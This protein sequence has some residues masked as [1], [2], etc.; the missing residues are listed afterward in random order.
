MAVVIKHPK[1][2]VDIEPEFSLDIEIT[3][4]VFSE[5]G[6]MTYPATLPS[7]AHNRMILNNAQ[8]IDA[9]NAP[10]HDVRVVVSDGVYRRTGKLNVLSAGLKSG[11]SINIGFDEGEMYSLFEDTALSKLNWPV[12]NYGDAYTAGDHLG[13]VMREEIEA[14][15]HVFP[16]QTGGE[17]VNNV[18]YPEYLNR[19]AFS[20]E[21]GRWELISEARYENCVTNGAVVKTMVPEGYGCTPFLKVHYI[22]KHIFEHFGYSL[23]ENPFASHIQLKRMVVLNNIADAIV[24]GTIDY[25]EFLPDCSINEFFNSLYVRTGMIYF[26]DGAKKTV[27]IKF[28]KDMVAARGTVDWKNYMAS[29]PTISFATPKRVVLSANTG[30]DGAEPQKETL[31]QFLAQYNNKVVEDKSILFADGGVC[32]EEVL[33]GEAPLFYERSTGR[34]YEFDFFDK[35]IKFKSTELFPWDTEDDKIEKEELTG[36][37]EC[38]AMKKVNWGMFAGLVPQYLAGY[39]H[40]HT[41]ISKGGSENEKE[42]ETPLAFCFKLPDLNV[43]TGNIYPYDAGGNKITGFDYALTFTGENGAFNRFFKD[44]DAI[45]RH[46]NSTVECEINLPR[47]TLFSVDLT[48]PVVID[49]QRFLIE[50]IKHPLPLLPDSPPK[51]KL[52]TLKL[53]EPYDL[54]EQE[55]PVARPWFKWIIVNGMHEKAQQLM[56]TWANLKGYP[57]AACSYKIDTKN[58]TEF[59]EKGD[60]PLKPPLTLNDTPIVCYYNMKV[61]FYFSKF[62]FAENKV[63]YPV[64]AKPDYTFYWYRDHT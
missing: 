57:L 64:T 61:I 42:G 25:S 14:D 2:I 21:S 50:S 52:R 1:G 16:V 15:Y 55:I 40:H 8:R 60:F 41:V 48:Q 33:N 44:Y 47:P 7:S 31:K 38:L 49:G 11:I 58:Y 37:D 53:L 18:Y 23:T 54:S 12:E 51:L 28:L 13:Q 35:S 46:A 27:R 62:S 36:D 6:S 9:V 32:S 56:E 59:P 20:Q 5:R 3:N 24:R 43:P 39:V 4:P 10:D 30:F 26:A 63:R 22:L 17:T 29:S 19:P 34:Y 45:L